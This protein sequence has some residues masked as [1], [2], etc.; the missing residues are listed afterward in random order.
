MT[1]NH[2]K[3]EAGGRSNNGDGPALVEAAE[4]V[5]YGRRERLQGGFS[6]SEGGRGVDAASRQAVEVGRNPCPAGRPSTWRAQ[7]WTDD[8]RRRIVF[9]SARAAGR[10]SV[11]PSV[12]PVC[13]VCPVCIVRLAAREFAVAGGD[14]PGYLKRQTARPT[15][16]TQCLWM[17][18]LVGRCILLSSE[19]LF[20]LL[21]VVAGWWCSLWGGIDGRQRRRRAASDI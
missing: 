20:F 9:V 8:G 7:R 3:K 13:P 18:L 15:Q 21:S 16:V 10:E 1:D 11:C 12:C 14:A 17:S 6:A 4:A 19:V 2:A 5:G